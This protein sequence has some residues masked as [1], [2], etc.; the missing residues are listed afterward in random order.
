MP[1]RPALYYCTCF[2]EDFK[3]G[4]GQLARFL[5]GGYPA[6]IST[7]N[8]PGL[9]TPRCVVPVLPNRRERHPRRR[10]PSLGNPSGKCRSRPRLTIVVAVDVKSLPGVLLKND[11]HFLSHR[12]RREIAREVILNGLWSRLSSARPSKC[13]VA[14]QGC[15]SSLF[16]RFTRRTSK[17]VI[18]P[19]KANPSGVMLCPRVPSPS[20]EKG[21]SF[22]KPLHL[23]LR[24]RIA[25]QE[26]PQLRLNLLKAR[27]SWCRLL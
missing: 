3:T 4:I 26:S 23:Q 19:A 18:K 1:Q 12:M 5:G 9:S 16:G 25:G 20:P 17:D 7:A 24:C 27:F 22:T 2:A 13:L 10:V 8:R 14:E 21:D 11:R 6:L 15:P